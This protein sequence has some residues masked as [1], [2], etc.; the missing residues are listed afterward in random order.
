MTIRLS[1][2]SYKGHTAGQCS[3][4]FISL[5]GRLS[6]VG[7]TPQSDPLIVSIASIANGVHKISIHIIL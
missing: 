2:R 5:G 3:R 6:I 4:I 1:V 7:L